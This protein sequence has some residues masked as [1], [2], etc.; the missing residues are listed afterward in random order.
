[1]VNCLDGVPPPEHLGSWY[2]PVDDIMILDNKW[3]ASLLR[4][5]AEAAV[6]RN[7]TAEEDGVCISAMLLPA[8]GAALRALQWGQ[9]Y[10]NRD[11]ETA[12]SGRMAGEDEAR[13]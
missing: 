4:E 12:T 6:G 2:E 1:M 9:Y 5:T 11:E 7:A 8:R 10:D 13:L 3:D